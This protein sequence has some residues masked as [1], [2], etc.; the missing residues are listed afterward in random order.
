MKK[1]RMFTTRRAVL[2]AAVFLTI[3]VGCSRSGGSRFNGTNNSSVAVPVPP[4]QAPSVTA[5]N[6]LGEINP[7]T[8]AVVNAVPPFAAPVQFSYVLDDN[9]D[10]PLSLLVEFA[11]AATPTQFQTAT[12]LSS[13]N[14]I[15]SLLAV[16]Y[17]NPN[18]PLNV[19][20]WDATTDLGANGMALN[21]TVQFRITPID[22][23]NTGA[24]SAVPNGI[25][26]GF[27]APPNNVPSI[28][29]FAP[30]STAQQ[31]GRVTFNYTVADA[32]NTNVTLSVF[33]VGPPATVGGP[34]PAPQPMTLI[35]VNGNP[36]APVDGV[37]VDPNNPNVITVGPAQF[38]GTF[39]WDSL[40]DIGISA[41][42]DFTFQ[43]QVTDGI[44][45]GTNVTTPTVSIGNPTAAFVQNLNVIGRSGNINLGLEVFDSDSDACAIS[46]E[47]T[48]NGTNFIPMTLAAP[49][50]GTVAGNTI[51]GVPSS[52]SG[53]G[54]TLTWT[55]TAD[56]P[57]GV[58]SGMIRVTVVDDDR[59]VTVPTVLPSQQ[60]NPTASP[61][62]NLFIHGGSAGF[63]QG[64][65]FL[66]S[67]TLSLAGPPVV[68]S[69]RAPGSVTNPF[70]APTIFGGTFS[71]EGANFGTDETVVTVLINNIS[72]NVIEADSNVVLV[73]LVF[74]TRTG[75]LQVIVNGVPSN[76]VPV[77]I[78][79]NDYWDDSTVTDAFDQ[80]SLPTTADPSVHGQFSDLDGDGDLDVVIAQDGANSILINQNA[81]QNV[82]TLNPGPFTITPTTNR[83]DVYIVKSAISRNRGPFNVN[84][85]DNLT[86][87]TLNQSNGPNAVVTVPTV[88]TSAATMASVIPSGQTFASTST[89]YVAGLA[90]Q[91]ASTAT[92]GSSRHFNASVLNRRHLEIFPTLPFEKITVFE[93]STGPFPNRRPL[94]YRNTYAQG[95]GSSG[96]D[97][98]VVGGTGPFAV[99][100][101]VNNG[102]LSSI[103]ARVVDNG[104]S[105]FN[106]DV[107]PQPGFAVNQTLINQ[108]GTPATIQSISRNP[109]VSLGGQTLTLTLPTGSNTALSIANMLNDAAITAGLDVPG[110]TVNLLV[111][112]TAGFAVGTA[113]TNQLG[114]TGTVINV[115]DN[116]RLRVRSTNA[117]NTG[118]SV[119][120]GGNV[121]AT[122]SSLLETRVDF[123]ARTSNNGLTLDL[124]SNDVLVLGNGS[125]NQPLGF[126]SQRLQSLQAPDSNRMFAFPAEFTDLQ[127]SVGD[128]TSPGNQVVTVP[129]T[130][131]MSIDAVRD[132][133]NNAGLQAFLGGNTAAGVFSASVEQDGLG[134]REFIELTVPDPNDS[135]H[136]LDQGAQRVLGFTGRFVKPHARGLGNFTDETGA[137]LPGQVSEFSTKIEVFD[138]DEDG[139]PDL[140][141]SNAVGLNR[142]LISANRGV[143]VDQSATLLPNLIDESFAVA[144]G[145]LDNDGDLDIA[146][147]NR[148][149]DRLLENRTG[150]LDPN[151]GNAPFAAGTMTDRS[152]TAFQNGPRS[153]FDKFTSDVQIG[154]MDGDGMLDLVY[155]HLQR[156]DGANGPRIYF[157][158]NITFAASTVTVGKFNQESLNYMDDGAQNL[159]LTRESFLRQF[160]NSSAA[161]LNVNS[162]FSLALGDINAD[163][164]ID[165]VAGNNV[166]GS[167]NFQNTAFVQSPFTITITPDDPNIRFVKNQNIF[168]SGDTAKAQGLTVREVLR[169]FPVIGQDTIVLDNVPNLAVFTVGQTVTKEPT[170]FTRLVSLLVGPVTNMNNKLFIRVDDSAANPNL[171]Q[172]GDRIIGGTGG[173]TA[174]ILSIIDDIDN[175]AAFDLLEVADNTLFAVG[176]LVSEVPSSGT[177]VSAGLTVFA[178]RNQL[179]PYEHNIVAGLSDTFQSL[180]DYPENFDAANNIVD[181]RGSDSSKDVVLGDLNSIALV[182]ART[183]QTVTG[184]TEAVTSPLGGGGT[185]FARFIVFA[186]NEDRTDGIFEFSNILFVINK[187]NGSKNSLSD[188]STPFLSTPFVNNDPANTRSHMPADTVESFGVDMGDVDNDGDLDILFLNGG[189]QGA[190]SQNLLYVANIQPA[191]LN[192]FN[193]AIP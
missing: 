57:A 146:V 100:D 42:A 132:A 43:A 186:N 5:L 34:P 127:I 12:L 139:D 46:F 31:T 167:F 22:A 63:P 142:L 144:T 41:F 48:F 28:V 24:S 118:D 145:D 91:T 2:L 35:Q 182:P 131:T 27:P 62:P 15:P 26:F 106:L 40:T 153:A 119:L 137:R 69:V 29:N 50:V 187:A 11:R 165:V 168:L 116:N 77:L 126:K 162:N 53:S 147:A 110:Q 130:G 117:F 169:N 47:V 166:L 94:G 175:P 33:F 193:A 161:G 138:A 30:A 65:L 156:Q 179:P 157:N 120:V 151:N 85:L 114:S 188:N 6:V 70:Y 58:T 14:P 111:S 178:S 81:N 3:P 101:V 121:L 49:T 176:E 21:E 87:T 185:T 80:A 56:I 52:P 160:P 8:G 74:G 190:G 104:N 25:S 71:I 10:E 9:E 143:F 23:A 102:N 159:D 181:H 59:A 83:L 135:I 115:I 171:F 184:L 183:P 73:N 89:A 136:I 150:E 128:G 67:P 103:I 75:L 155:G 60:P 122:V 174:E 61:L 72:Q 105:T 113:I 98:L 90:N 37:P 16:N 20:T 95:F 38:T 192:N 86:I 96:T 7:V 99:G 141:V 134:G 133:I 140:L 82:S 158:R 1:F 177:I 154:D 17:E 191:D 39:V 44:D 45:A 18:S 88:S 107:L 32:D 170:P 97:L 148:G 76:S 68:A 129:L 64:T 19:F 84:Q 54:L 108:M 36:A 93:S 66:L 4:S 189:A 109:G 164:R 92:V 149:R 123:V 78:R 180:F 172:V 55:S 125:A 51:N 112:T 152:F 173:N 79:G 124:F 13:A 163:G